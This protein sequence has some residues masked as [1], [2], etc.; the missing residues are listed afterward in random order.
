MTACRSVREAFFVF[1]RAIA[2]LLA[3]VMAKPVSA[4][5]D[6]E[7]R[8]FVEETERVLAKLSDATAA[9]YWDDDVDQTPEN[10]KRAQA[11]ESAF[12]AESVARAVAARRYNPSD[13]VLLRK[14]KRLALAADGLNADPQ[15]SKRRTELQQQMNTHYE[16]ACASVDPGRPC[17][18]RD[19]IEREIRTSRD[20]ERL[21]RLW[22]AWYDTAQPQASRYQEHT[23]LLN[24]GARDSGRRDASEVSLAAYETDPAS[25]ERDLDA[26]WVQV[27]PLYRL[28]HAY[29]RA[30]LAVRYPGE[31]DPKGP[32]PMHLLGNLWG[33]EWEGVA[34]ILAPGNNRDDT[35]D[36]FKQAGLTP[37]RMVKVADGFFTSLG[38]PALPSSFW[39][40]SYFERP[41]G[42]DGKPK[43]N[44]ACHPTAYFIAPGDW[45]LRTCFTPNWADFLTAHHE[46]GHIFYFQSFNDQPYLLR[47]AP[48]AGINEAVGDAVMLSVTPAYLQKIGLP[49]IAPTGGDIDE[50]LR[51]ALR[52]VA[53]IPFGLMLQR[54]RWGV[55][56]GRIPPERYNV[57]WWELV[58]EYQGLAPPAPRPSTAFDPAAKKHIAADIDYIRYFL[59]DVL[60]FQIHEAL[61]RKAGCSEELH[62]CSIYESQ[63]AGA[64]FRDAL[65]LGASR[66]WQDVL[67]SLTGSPTARGEPLQTYLA[68]LKPWL[69]QQTRGLPIGWE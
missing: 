31:V 13:P 45:R 67:Q 2:L 60:T 25:F 44:F 46:T 15:A 23:E 22:I 5:T 64:Q 63:A 48:N 40:R 51:V 69:E 52:K 57:A 62:R 3:L 24:Q 18:R 17:L 8:A 47:D 42:P 66:P 39:E 27:R 32:I 12:I 7:A 54:W 37:L 1:T 38:F 53:R 19:E 30:R 4:Q 35:S 26:L 28:L 9:A 68:P 50:L 29:A 41:L 61:S 59:A 58:R 55:Q 34:D 10:S 56:S 43:P 21:R 14:L 20:P 49:A 36:A 11:A 33:Q 65:S 16:Q 6:D